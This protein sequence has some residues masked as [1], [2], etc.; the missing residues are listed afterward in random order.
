ML[1]GQCELATKGAVP[2][3]IYPG[4]VALCEEGAKTFQEKGQPE[5]ESHYLKWW[6][7]FER[8]GTRYAISLVTSQRLSLKPKKR[9]S[10]ADVIRAAG[11]DPTQ[12]T[13]TDAYLGKGVALTVRDGEQFAEIAD[14]QPLSVVAGALAGA[15]AGARGEAYAAPG[16]QVQFPSFPAPQVQAPL[17]QNAAAGTQPVVGAT[18]AVSCILCATQGKAVQFPHAQALAQHVQQTHTGG[19]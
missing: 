18:G 15:S 7:V 8:S 12:A 19:R 11:G 6:F 3:G 2:Y 14:V 9:P 4:V 13:D 1:E 10:L 17:Q 16:S 5:R